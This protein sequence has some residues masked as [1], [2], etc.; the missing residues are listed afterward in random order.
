MNEPSTPPADLQQ[1]LAHCPNVT[2]VGIRLCEAHIEPYPESYQRSLVTIIKDS[3][4]KLRT[5]TCDADGFP[6]PSFPLMLMQELSENQLEELRVYQSEFNPH[7]LD[8]EVTKAVFQRHFAS[9]RVIDFSDCAGCEDGR[10]GR[11]FE[12]AEGWKFQD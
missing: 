9:L 7:G 2:S 6:T 3:C 4:P 1:A 8:R 11:F 5:L 12:S 10:M